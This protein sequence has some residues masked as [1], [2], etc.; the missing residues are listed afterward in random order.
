MR[1]PNPRNIV[2]AVA[3]LALFF[4]ET[5]LRAEPLRIALSVVR[6]PGNVPD[7]TVMVTDTTS[8]YGSVDYLYSIGTYDVTL[9]QYAAFLNAVAKTDPYGLYDTRLDSNAHNH[10]KG[11]RR[12]GAP[13]HYSYS[14]IG[15]G[16]KPVTYVN[17]LDS[18]RFCN[19]LQNGQLSGGTETGA[20]TLNGDT[21][22]GLETRNPGATWWIPSENEWYKAAYYDPSLNAGTGGYW[23]YPTRSN[24]I[25]GNLIGS[26]SNEANYFNGVYSVT[27]SS[28]ENGAQNYLTAVGAFT[29]SA[30]YYGTFD[31]GGDVYQL[32]E[33]VA[34]LARGVRGGQWGFG[35]GDLQS[36]DREFRIAV[37]GNDGVG[38]R[39]ATWQGAGPGNFTLLL[40]ATATGPGIP[41][42]TG[43]ATMMIGAKGGVIMAG[44][45]PDGESFNIAGAL[46]TSNS[47]IQFTIDKALAYPAVTNQGSSGFLFGALNF[48]KLS[49]TNDFSGTLEWIKPQQNLGAYP[50][51][52]DTNLNVIGS[53][54]KPGKSLLPGFTTGL[55]ELTDTGALSVSG[56][57]PLNQPVT[58]T[59]ANTLSL[60]VPIS[61]KLT[62]TI[63]PSTGVFKGTFLYPVK[64]PKLIDFSGI[65]FQD[66]TLGGGFF[67]G[68]N[69]SG[70]VTL[71]PSP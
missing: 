37:N 70:T 12:T 13:G 30:S 60:T 7:P 41:Q 55:L 40:S 5:A 16:Q 15:D 8:G 50:A 9:S 17:W 14:V 24:A 57:T 10:I 18:A 69:G 42:G 66:Q 53:L 29:N 54:Y 38:F 65:L 62:V 32:N 67:I 6:N 35:A 64:P 20:Y 43:Y 4:A 22:S 39:V 2:T 61:D 21:T 59:P 46:V 19:W 44:R 58:L 45:L 52:I 27:Q 25:P 3:L 56:T 11:I 36:S 47:G 63:T 48:N 51:A 33:A 31:Q 34:G 23:S 1:S 68:P 49:G 28:I 71:T 26:G